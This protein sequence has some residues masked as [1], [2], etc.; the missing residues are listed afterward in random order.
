MRFGSRREC[1]GLL[2]SNMDPVKIA[3]VANRIRNAVK[4]ITGDSLNSCHSRVGEHIDE[5]FS[6]GF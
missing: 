6:Y 1:G 2:V 3:A 5:K 4:R